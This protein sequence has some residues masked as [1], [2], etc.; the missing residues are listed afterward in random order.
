MIAV[1]Q[2]ETE[3]GRGDCMAACM[4]TLLGLGPDD[5]PNFTLDR[6]PWSGLQHWLAGRGL[7]LLRLPAGDPRPFADLVRPATCVLIGDSPRH[8]DLTHAVVGSVWRDGC[9]VVHD[10]HPSKAG[11]RGS[12]QFIGIL[13]KLNN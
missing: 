12:P 9:E 4:A 10:P 7:F 8:D 13:C 6:D 5:V 1:W 11:L 3:R 2:R